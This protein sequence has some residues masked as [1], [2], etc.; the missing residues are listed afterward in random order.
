MA[1]TPTIPHAALLE[2]LKKTRSWTRVTEKNKD[3]FY[4]ED[5]PVVLTSDALFVAGGNP[6]L[7]IPD[8][9]YL[10]DVN[11]YL[12]VGKSGIRVWLY[13]PAI[14]TVAN[15]VVKGF[16]IMD[17]M[18]EKRFKTAKIG[19]IAAAVAQMKRIVQDKLKDYKGIQGD[20]GEFEDNEQK[21]E[22]VCWR[23]SKCGVRN[24][25]VIVDDGYGYEYFANE[26]GDHGDYIE[27]S[28]CEEE[29]DVDEVRKMLI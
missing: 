27:C 19:E 22:V 15:Q 24:T 4:H 1:K 28:D 23:C 3:N 12:F 2:A 16:T 17:G 9:G 7:H 8:F 21:T 5:A 20:Q 6:T 10:D 18:I 11:Q 14:N 29:V 26:D 13:Q 25:T